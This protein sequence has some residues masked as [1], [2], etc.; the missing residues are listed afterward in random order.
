MCGRYTLGRQPDSLLDYFH[1]H[2]EMPA[3]HLSW[4]IA[5]TQS[6]PVI[7]HDSEQ[8]RIC[9][10]MRWGLVP[11]WSKGPD[12]RFNMI[13]ARAETLDQKPAYK[14]AY[15]QQRCLVPCDGFYE[16]SA[17]PDSKAKQPY[18]IS[19]R[20]N[21]LFALAGIWDQ[22]THPEQGEVLVS[23]SIITTEASPFMKDIHHRMPVILDDDWYDD[24]LSADNNG[25]EVLGSL[26]LPYQPA[27]L[28]KHPVSKAVN[29]A[30]NDS[31]ELIRAIEV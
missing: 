17:S 15:R 29:S 30:A 22:W 5:P 12:P 19:R 1:L 7:I 14:K 20:D 31:P 9:R 23:F 13:N 6:A 4:N 27:E 21:S 10:M 3:Y 16:W 25:R 26:L 2:G 24:W 8:R 28:T 11:G 18:F